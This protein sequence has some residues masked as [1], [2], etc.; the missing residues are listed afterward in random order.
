M[1]LRLD[2]EHIR[3][4]KMFFGKLQSYDIVMIETM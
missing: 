2:V 1:S 3:C 4:C